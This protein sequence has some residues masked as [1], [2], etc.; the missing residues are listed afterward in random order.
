MVWAKFGFGDEILGWV[1]IGEHKHKY[2]PKGLVSSAQRKCCSEILS[3]GKVGNPFVS[4]A[5]LSPAIFTWFFIGSFKGWGLGTAWWWAWGT[6]K[7]TGLSSASDGK[8]RFAWQPD[9]HLKKKSEIFR[10]LFSLVVYAMKSPLMSCIHFF[11]ASAQTPWFF[12]PRLGCAGTI[13]PTNQWKKGGIFL[14]KDVVSLFFKSSLNYKKN[15]NVRKC[16]SYCFLM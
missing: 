11:S 12:I 2:G 10:V 7:V 1:F 15:S 14:F 13:I 5:N 8:Y 4:L 6:T 9:S 3:S 16:E